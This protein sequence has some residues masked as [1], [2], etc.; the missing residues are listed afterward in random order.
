ML[1]WVLRDRRNIN[2]NKTTLLSTIFKLFSV[3]GRLQKEKKF[4]WG[5]WLKLG[6]LGSECFLGANMLLGQFYNTY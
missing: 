5:F 6:G 4:N 1:S 3:K 2:S